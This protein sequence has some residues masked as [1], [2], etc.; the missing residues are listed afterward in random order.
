MDAYVRIWN[1]KSLDSHNYAYIQAS[2]HT[3]GHRLPQTF[4]QN[5]ENDDAAVRLRE[6]AW[7]R[8]PTTAGKCA[9][10]HTMGWEEPE[11]TCGELWPVE[12]RKACQLECEFGDQ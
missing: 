1:A 6:W 7:G 9:A 3:S 12:R 5:W 4:A 10:T 2:N 11:M 8:W